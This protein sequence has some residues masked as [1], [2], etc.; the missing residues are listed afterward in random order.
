MTINGKRS[1][2]TAV[3]WRCV[4]SHF[5]PSDGPYEDPYE[6]AGG[7]WLTT[8]EWTALQDKLARAEQDRDD[9]NYQMGEA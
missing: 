7:K 3:P 6:S 2:R 4:V 8:S 1:S 5:R 9:L